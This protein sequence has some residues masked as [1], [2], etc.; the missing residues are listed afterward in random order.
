MSAK[1]VIILFVIVLT[2]LIGGGLALVG[3]QS[4]Q[5]AQTLLF[6]PRKTAATT[7]VNF[8]ITDWQDVTFQ[9]GDV[10]IGGWYIPPTAQADGATLIF[11]HGFG[12]D[13]SALLEQAAA[14]YKS[15]YGALLIDL[16]NSGSSQG[17]LTS[18]GY[19]EAE[20]VKA[21]FAY[22]QTRPEV[23]PARIGIVGKS[24]GG[25]AV[26]RAAAQ[27]PDVWVV[28]AESTYSSLEGNMPAISQTIARVSSSYA[29]PVY[30]WMK[31]LS[32]LPLDEIRPIDYLPQITAPVLFVH[33][34]RDVVVDISHSQRMFQAANDPKQLLIIPNGTHMNIFTLDPARFEQEVGAFLAAHTP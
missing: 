21:A 33:G 2:I 24:A 14:L 6:P 12:A 34:D 22:L 10:T 4:R 18:W 13:R 31:Q 11:V 23:N 30:W 7:P 5:A 20:D 32:G 3:V 16:R 26:I 8:G 19:W 25:A 15:G 17:N 27:L 9:S 28:I 29:A 1:T